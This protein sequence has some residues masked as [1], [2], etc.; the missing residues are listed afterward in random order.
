M[1]CRLFDCVE[2]CH[3]YE[4]W[5]LIGLLYLRNFDE[6]DDLTQ[7]SLRIQS[8]IKILHPCQPTLSIIEMD[9][10]KS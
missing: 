2:L 8:I 7:L 6:I 3:L 1:D 9:M 4:P 10:D 5:L